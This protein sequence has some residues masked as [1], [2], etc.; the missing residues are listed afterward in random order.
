MN[1][2]YFKHPF[3]KEK[4]DDG[5]VHFSVTFFGL[6]IWNARALV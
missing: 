1:L 4:N 5:D 6:F 2:T 3:Q